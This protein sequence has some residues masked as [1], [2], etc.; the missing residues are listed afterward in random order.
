MRPSKVSPDKPIHLV[1]SSKPQLL[2]CNRCM[3]HTHDLQVLD[4]TRRTPSSTERELI[5]VDL[6][7]DSS[8]MPPSCW[9]VWLD[10]SAKISN[11]SATRTRASARGE[12]T[13]G[14]LTL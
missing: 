9:K 5:S 2:L 1:Q 11:L 12:P 8:M 6:P 14:G 7:H 10:D 4:C 3:R 13:E